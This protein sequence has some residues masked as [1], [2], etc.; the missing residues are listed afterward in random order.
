MVKMTFD[1]RLKALVS[2]NCSIGTMGEKVKREEERDSNEERERGGE[3][4]G[5]V[6]EC[7][8]FSAALSPADSNTV[9]WTV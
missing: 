9:G 7:E 5:D 6:S 4:A 1:N 3:L 2:T 8:S